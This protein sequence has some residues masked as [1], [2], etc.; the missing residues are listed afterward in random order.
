MQA[1][2]VSARRTN[3]RTIPPA[4]FSPDLLKRQFDVREPN[5]VWVT[6]TTYVRTYEGWLYL[7][8]AL[9]LFSLQ[10]VG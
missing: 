1:L 4:V 3:T 2:V 5:N 8:V 7:A 10:F 6:R 9:D